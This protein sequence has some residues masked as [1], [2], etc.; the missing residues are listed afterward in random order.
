MTP[1]LWMIEEMK[2]I[3][4]SWGRG[5]F[6]NIERRAADAANHLLGEEVWEDLRVVTLI[7][8]AERLGDDDFCTF[9]EN[10]SS[11]STE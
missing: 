5:K 6:L 7:H 1:E 9:V 10:Y 11:P 2:K 4:Q 8:D 3:E